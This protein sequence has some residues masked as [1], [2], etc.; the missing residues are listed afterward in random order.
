[1]HI[2][3]LSTENCYSVRFFALTENEESDDEAKISSEVLEVDGEKIVIEKQDEADTSNNSGKDEDKGETDGSHVIDEDDDKKGETDSAQVIDDDE[4]D[5]DDKS[6]DVEMIVDE[7]NDDEDKSD[8][9]K[10]DTIEINGDDEKDSETPKEQNSTTEET[11][12]EKNGKQ[13]D[14]ENLMEVEES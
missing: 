4:K 3:L 13:I 1:M 6:S 11:E 14:L 5:D 9:A 10:A 7:D 8:D 2:P 12:D